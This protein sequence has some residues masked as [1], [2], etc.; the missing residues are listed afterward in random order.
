MCVRWILCA[1]C[2]GAA[3]PVS[4]QSEP[5]G[6]PTNS[7]ILDEII[8]TAKKTGEQSRL[9]T[10]M[11]ISS[12]DSK[13]LARRHI[14]GMND[15]LRFEPGTNFIDRGT[16]R[17]S[18]IIR[19]ITADPGR[20]GVITGIYIDETPV[21]GLGFAGTGSPDLG[22]VDIERVEVLRGPQGTLYGAGSMSGTV[23]T[24]TRPPDLESFGGYV[25]FDGSVTSGYGDSN[26]DI[27]GV[28]NLPLV[29]DQF[30]IRA[31][32]YR[33]DKSG[34]IRNMARDD[35]A[36]QAGEQQFGARFS[37]TVRDRG[38]LETE[39]Y[40]VGALWRVTNNLDIRMTALGQDTS[41][42]GLPTID[43][44][45]GPFE[46][47]RFARLDGSDEGMTDDLQILSLV[48]DYTAENWS[49]VSAS[50]WTDYESDIDWDVGIFFLDAFGGVEPPFWIHQGFQEEVFTQEVRWVWDSGRRLHTLLGVFYEDRRSGFDQDLLIEG[51]GRQPNPDRTDSSSEQVSLFTDLV[52]SLS[53]DWEINAGVRLFDY[54]FRSSTL[55]SGMSSLSSHEETGETFKVGANWRPGSGFPGEQPLL[56][57]TWSEGF[58]PG[59]PV[60][61]IPPNCDANGDGIVDGIGL[62]LND[63]ESDDLRS[64]ELGYKSTFAQR[65]AALEVAIFHIEWTNIPVA[66]AA[67]PPCASTFPFNAGEA[68]SHGIE[69]GIDTLLTDKLQLNIS[70]SLVEAELTADTPGVGSTGDRLPASPKYNLYVSLEYLTNWFGNDGWL[71]GE[72]ARVGDYF[73]NLPGDPPRLG[74]YTQ[75]NMS[76][77]LSIDRWIVEAY[78]NN[79]ADADDATWANP[80]WAPYDRETRLRPRTIG[81]RIRYAFGRN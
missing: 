70:G 1:V 31:V 33:F 81:A 42:D 80:I 26:N 77:G 44:L 3:M 63:I 27:Q 49:L 12:I 11:A 45:Q 54:E 67:P 10:A 51:D 47:S 2:L 79:L 8:V 17:N 30:A 46:Q 78:V 35:P 6:E 48:V 16:A 76:A 68:R 56:Y 43:I 29:E 36:K 20:G 50:A 23:R 5:V 18:V 34:Y 7:R 62:P 32:A 66:L 58:R 22:I 21:Q 64:L 61:E 19:G 60:G 55:F 24:L 53:E 71:R 57:L 13:Q 40:R 72:V 52:Y 73:N 15:Y 4:G 59:Y 14:E 37:D 75:I 39:G 9:N 74:D 41:Q 65:R 25:S 38:A 28:L 69:F